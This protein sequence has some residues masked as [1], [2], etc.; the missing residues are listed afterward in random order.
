VGATKLGIDFCSPLVPGVLLDSSL[1]RVGL[2]GIS[3]MIKHHARCSFG[4][5]NGEIGEKFRKDS[6]CRHPCREL[7]KPLSTG[8]SSAHRGSALK[9]SFCPI[10]AARAV[11]HKW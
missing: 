8:Y 10:K 7:G 9:R 1:V 2:C 4:F 6:E 3:T 5:D 11:V